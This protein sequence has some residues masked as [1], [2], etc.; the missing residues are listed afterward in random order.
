VEK[1]SLDNFKP[2]VFLREAKA[3][4]LQVT[5]PTKQE[6]IRLTGVVIV[7]SVVVGLFLGGADFLLTSAMGLFLQK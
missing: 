1:P 6:T 5:W 2:F 7:S 3:E 4:L